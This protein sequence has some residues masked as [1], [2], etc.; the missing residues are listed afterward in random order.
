MTIEK[1][2]KTAKVVWAFDVF[3]ASSERESMAEAL[4]CW[5]GSSTVAV[6]PV[7]V[8]SSRSLPISEPVYGLSLENLQPEILARMKTELGHLQVPGLV[9]PVLLTAQSPSNRSAAKLLGDYAASAGAEL[10][11]V[12]TRASSGLAHLVVGSFA[13]TLILQPKVP[14][15]TLNP[16]SKPPYRI[17]SI[18]FP[19]DLS[20]A[21]DELLE[22]TI[23]P[24]AKKHG[25]RVTLLH[26]TMFLNEHPEASFGSAK[27]Y[28]ALAEAELERQ[29]KRLETSAGRLE[30]I[31]SVRMEWLLV[32]DEPHPADAILAEAEKRG[33]SLICLLSQKEGLEV[34]I[35]GSVSRE[36]LRR[37]KVPV[38]I[39]HAKDAGR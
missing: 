19:T 37:A 28:V 5:M 12:S 10:V 38:L 11:A 22:G 25:A 21:C 6:E 1:T 16:G 30:Q 17:E 31:H 35:L 24:L 20:T 29:S 36:V 27:A 23:V 4:K 33:V 32:K 18:L 7:Y 15:L 3:G 26:S 39:H 34:P 13:E 8:M 9:E 14:V 2:S